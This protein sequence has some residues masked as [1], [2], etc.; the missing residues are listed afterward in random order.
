[1]RS[2]SIT[3]VVAAL[4][5]SV[6]AVPCSDL[7]WS[8]DGGLF[9]NA[10]PFD[11]PQ[12]AWDVVNANDCWVRWQLAGPGQTL[13]DAKVT[14]TVFEATESQVRSTIKNYFNNGGTNIQ[15]WLPMRTRSLQYSYMLPGNLGDDHPVID[16]QGSLWDTS[17][18][19]VSIILPSGK[20]KLEVVRLTR[21]GEYEQDVNVDRAQDVGITGLKGTISRDDWAYITGAELRLNMRSMLE[22][23][24]RAHRGNRVWNRQD[25]AYALAEKANGDCVVI[26]FRN[27]E[28][29]VI[30]LPP[31]SFR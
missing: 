25:F 3:L 23:Q 24:K 10:H 22:E 4:F 29:F 6:T 14:K 11:P 19:M 20:Q 18:V 8:E 26:D 5:G 21:T 12:N 17:R 27:F 9:G 31:A 16:P 2:Q 30:R 1:M 28:E 15:L 7:G 13:N